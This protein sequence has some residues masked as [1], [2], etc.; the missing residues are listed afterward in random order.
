MTQKDSCGYICG[1]YCYDGRWT[2]TMTP[3]SECV[4]AGTNSGYRFYH[5]Q[6]TITMTKYDGSTK[7]YSGEV[8]TKAGPVGWAYERYNTLAECEAGLKACDGCVKT[9]YVIYDS[10]NSISYCYNCPDTKYFS[11]EQ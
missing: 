6:G 2:L 8:T 7:T 11:A 10:C 9:N 1:I 3:T 4:W 5:T